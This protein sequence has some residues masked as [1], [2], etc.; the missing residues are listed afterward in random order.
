MM[1]PAKLPREQIEVL[2]PADVRLYLTSRGWIPKQIDT[3]QKAIEFSNRAY[4]DVELL[5]P[6]KREVGDFAARM[7]EVVV[8][9]AALEKRSV[10]EI[11]GEL[12]GP[13]GDVVRLRVVAPDAAL[14]NLPLDEGIRLLRG[15]RDMLLAAAF[16][17]LRPQT[18]HP[19]RLPREVRGF[20]KTCR[21]GQTERGSFVATL[22]TPVPPELQTTMEFDDPSLRT[23]MERYPRRVTINLMST[24]GFVSKS[25]VEGQP[26]RILDGIEHGVSANL[27]E[28]L[29]D[30]KPQGDQSSL[31]ISVSWAR[32]RMTIPTGVPQSVSFPHESFSFIEEAGKELRVRAFAKPARYEGKL[33]G[34]E[35]VN[36]PFNPEPVGR[37]VIVADVAGETAKLKVDLTPEDFSRACLALPMGKRVRVTGIIVNDVKSRVYELSDPRNFEV[38][39]DS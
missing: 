28:A 18:L 20:L 13:P 29:G 31:D 30:M 2:R 8:G 5:L 3:G 26:N 39:D 9:L 16:S 33:I 12:S 23:R 34:T 1:S 32:N 21:L 11:L 10:W 7:A 36:R 27:C 35:W 15:G 38:R 6:M 17:T 37:V 25:I 14:G 24:L 4:P 22:I 19:Q